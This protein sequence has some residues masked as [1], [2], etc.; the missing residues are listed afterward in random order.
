MNRIQTHD[1]SRKLSIK[2]FSLFMPSPHKLLSIYK[3]GV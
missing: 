1:Y 3:E 2:D